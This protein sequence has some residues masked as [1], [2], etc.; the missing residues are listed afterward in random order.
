M[1]ANKQQQQ[2]QRHQRHRQQQ[3]HIIRVVFILCQMDYIFACSRISTLSLFVP[4]VLCTLAPI[5][6]HTMF[7]A[8]D[9]QIRAALARLHSS[10]R[11]SLFN[12]KRIRIS[13]AHRVKHMSNSISTRV[14]ASSSAATTAAVAAAITTDTS[15][16][17]NVQWIATAPSEQPYN[18]ILC[19]ISCISNILLFAQQQQR[20]KTFPAH[21]CSNLKQT[22]A[23]QKHTYY[24]YVRPFINI[25]NFNQIN[26]SINFSF[27]FPYSFGFVRY[28]S[29]SVCRRF[30]FSFCVCV[31]VL[32]GQ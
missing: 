7:I 5:S 18:F 2:H 17:A 12:A 29:L 19:S 20:Q 15:I 9:A 8:N 6:L 24:T 32:S 22:S 27:T 16:A 10:D 23:W 1:R 11:P 13:L 4:G 30:S 26:F 31:F 3:Q 25:S 28:F 14:L 21:L